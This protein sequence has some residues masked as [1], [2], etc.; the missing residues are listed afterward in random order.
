LQAAEVEN[1]DACF[2]YG[3]SAWDDDVDGGGGGGGRKDENTV[4][5]KDAWDEDDS[6]DE[7]EGVTVGMADMTLKSRVEL[8]RGGELKATV[9]MSTHADEVV[10]SSCTLVNEAGHVDHGTYVNESWHIYK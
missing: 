5:T 1:E 7:E 8:G 9:E 6:G 2:D 4:V 3:G 10:S